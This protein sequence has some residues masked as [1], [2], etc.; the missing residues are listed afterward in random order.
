VNWLPYAQ[1]IERKIQSL[2]I[3]EIS[4][5]VLHESQLREKR[6]L[7]V[8]NES[9][10]GLDTSLRARIQ[11]EF[12]SY[13]PLAPLLGDEEVTE[14]LVVSK[15]QI[16]FEKKGKLACLPDSFLSDLTYQNFIEK[17]CQDSGAHF[18]REHPMINGK[19]GDFRLHVISSE[20]TH[21][22]HS[23]SLRRH[24]KN[25]W[26]LIRLQEAG[27]GNDKDCAQIRKILNAKQSI[28]IV[29]P[30]GSGKTSMLNACLQELPPSERCILIEDTPELSIPNGASTKLVTR[31]D[32][33]RILPDIDQGELVRQSLRMRPDRLVMGEIRGS[34]AKD[35]L[36]ALSTGHGGSLATIHASQPQ[37]ALLRLEM[38]VQMGA[39]NWSLFAIR[40]LI[41]LSLKYILVV[42]K[43][44][45]GHREFL[46]IHELSSVEESGILLERID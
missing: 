44:S 1:Q 27:W 2:P 7:Q 40:N 25:P 42:G 46:G 9:T 8:L 43:N 28:L 4:F 38:L 34:E 5:G 32:A 11:D 35:F 6:I 21:Q 15:S 22:S 18:N 41:A 24:P 16:W 26:T 39:P 17:V 10:D 3:H 36:M 31:I 19:L 14:I 30:T 33:N 13:G 45:A 23:I 12:L 37:Q 20:I 29:G